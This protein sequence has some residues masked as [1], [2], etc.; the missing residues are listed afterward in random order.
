MRLPVVIDEAPSDVSFWRMWDYLT[1][2]MLTD[3]HPAAS[4]GL[5]VVV[6]DGLPL[7]PADLQGVGIIS[8]G[9]RGHSVPRGRDRW[10]MHRLRDNGLLDQARAAGYRVAV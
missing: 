5:P 4:R 6:R 7:G 3:D 10:C 2:G 9:S 8:I 1:D